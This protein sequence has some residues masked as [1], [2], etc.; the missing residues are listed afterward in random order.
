MLYA[1]KDDQRFLDYE[2]SLSGDNLYNLW[3][4]L[5]SFAILP[6]IFIIFQKNLFKI[7]DAYSTDELNNDAN[8]RDSFPSI[9][10]LTLSH[11]LPEQGKFFWSLTSLR[12]SERSF[13]DG[14]GGLNP[15]V[16]DV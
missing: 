9:L 2:A 4:S 5:R 12:V 16:P 15:T 3:E 13:N 14:S 10:V 1:Y 11:Q 7:S 8:Q 6:R